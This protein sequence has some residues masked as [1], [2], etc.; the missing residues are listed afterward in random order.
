VTDTLGGAVWRMPANGGPATKWFESPLLLGDGSFNFGFPLG[1]HG[2]VYRQDELVVSVT[3]KARLLRIPMTGGQP[4]LLSPAILA[5]NA[6]VS[7]D[8]TQAAFYFAD[9]ATGRFDLGVMPLNG[10]SMTK[11][12]DVVPSG[13]YAAVRWTARSRLRNGRPACSASLTRLSSRSAKL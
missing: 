9:T 7:P 13:A 1:A 4:Q 6:A 10:T 2:I 12:F 8:G 3:E 5:T 11:Q